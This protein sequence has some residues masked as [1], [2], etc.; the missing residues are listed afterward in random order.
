MISS[1]SGIKRSRAATGSVMSVLVWLAAL[2]AAAGASGAPRDSATPKTAPT[3][4]LAT[5]PLSTALPCN[6]RTQLGLDGCADRKLL[7]ADKLLNADIVVVWHLLGGSARNDFVSA[8]DA[9]LKYRNA[10]CKS[11]SDV[12]QGGTAQPMQ[13]LLCLAEDDASRRLDLKGFYDL[14]TQDMSFPPKFP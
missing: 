6:Q 12:Y 10:D 13:Y 3:P 2:T 11:Q 14:L 1:R 9:W 7:A 5:E 4:P 8:Q